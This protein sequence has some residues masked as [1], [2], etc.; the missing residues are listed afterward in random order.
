M[1]YR[2]FRKGKIGHDDVI[3][4]SYL[5]FKTYPK[6]SRIVADLY[7]VIF[8]DEYQ[9]TSE[10]V[11]DIIL[12]IIGARHKDRV[13]IGLFGDWMQSIYASGVGNV[14]PKD[15]GL[16]RIVKEENY[17]SSKRVVQVLNKIRGDICGDIYQSPKLDL[18][19]QARFYY[20]KNGDNKSVL[21]DL[22]EKLGDDKS[23]GSDMKILALTNK[24]VAQ[25]SGWENLHSIYNMYSKKDSR[26]KVENI[27]KGNDP[28]GGFYDYVENIISA[29]EKNDNVELYKIFR[30][31]F[32]QEKYVNKFGMF[33]RDLSRCLSDLKNRCD[34]GSLGDVSSFVL[35]EDMFPK[36]PDIKRL[37]R[38]VSS[39][40]VYSGSSEKGSVRYLKDCEYSEVR[41]LWRYRD[42]M[43]PFS[44]QHGT[45]GTEYKNIIA[46]L[47]NGGWS[48]YNFES[49]LTGNNN[50]KSNSIYNRSLNIL[51]V[52][53]SRAKENLAVL[54]VKPNDN[55]LDAACNIFGE[56]NVYEL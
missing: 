32:N 24:L 15:R 6:L 39:E 34:S 28:Y 23:W 1:D 2:D 40:T 5:M 4:L 17:R 27:L 26:F 49:A 22:L 13:L 25:N 9:D 3:E 30:N 50:K 38:E 33:K 7:P 46:I 45:K 20:K 10:K 43:T 53:L 36:N 55:V 12:N 21:E 16:E 54:M 47:D 48:M 51:Y 35:N 18:A 42:E 41:A 11:I 52:S 37:L 19:G 14:N 29:Y 44:T 56:D 31:Q 8:I